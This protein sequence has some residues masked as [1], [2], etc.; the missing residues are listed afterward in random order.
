M[1]ILEFGDTNNRKMIFIH[2]FQS[3]YQVWNKYIEHYQNDFHI[4]VPI[5]P[6]HNPKQKEDF[7]SFS[8][9][10]KEIED[11]CLSHYGEEVYAVYGMSMGGVLAATLWQSKRLKIEKVIFDGSPLVSV[12]SIM[13]KMMLCFYLKITHKSQQRDRKTLEQAKSFV[14]QEY[15]NDFLQVLDSMSDTTIINCINNIADFRL[16]DNIDTK[17]TKIYFYHGTAANE[18]LAKKSAKFLS[19]NYT[20]S[21]IK[22]FKGKAHCENAL[23]YPELMIKELDKVLIQS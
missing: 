1:E 2:G 18:M 15:L 11:Y 4:I 6:G 19:K 9:T 14:A 8:E 10:A 5:M 22:C 23:L 12:N 13:R 20:N 16:R 3:P 17:N 21:V 7:I